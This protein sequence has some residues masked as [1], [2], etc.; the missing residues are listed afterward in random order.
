MLCI[1]KERACKIVQAFYCRFG[2]TSVHFAITNSDATNLQALVTAGAN[3]N[4]KDDNGRAPLWTS[5]AEDG[6]LEHVQCLIN[7]GADV[8]LKD[9][10][11]KRTPLQV[12]D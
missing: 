12:T 3:L 9:G 7:A 11:E 2:K 4:S 5:V 10:R 1:G 6:H 8:N